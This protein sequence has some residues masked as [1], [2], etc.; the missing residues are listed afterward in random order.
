MV[1][2]LMVL[3]IALRRGTTVLPT[4]RSLLTPV[5]LFNQ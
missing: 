1:V 2:F 3:L 4:A 5:E